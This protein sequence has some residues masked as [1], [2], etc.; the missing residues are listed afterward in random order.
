MPISELQSRIKNKSAS[1]KK[2]RKKPRIRTDYEKIL[3]LEAQKSDLELEL[4]VKKNNEYNQRKMS[5]EIDELIE[6]GEKE[7]DKILRKKLR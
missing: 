4:A 2:E 5:K 3:L 1:I 7:K 6:K